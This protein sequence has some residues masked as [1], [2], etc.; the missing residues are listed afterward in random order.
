MMGGVAANSPVPGTNS[1]KTSNAGSRQTG[2]RRETTR[3]LLNVVAPFSSRRS[4]SGMAVA[5]LVAIAVAVA[6]VFSRRRG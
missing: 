3:P 1:R 5:E 6:G 2:S 4:N